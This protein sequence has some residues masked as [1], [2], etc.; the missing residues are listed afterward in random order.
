MKMVFETIIFSNTELEQMGLLG[1]AP[2]H[3]RRRLERE[4]RRALAQAGRPA[5]RTLH[6]PP[7]PPPRPLT[8]SGEAGGNLTI[9]VRSVRGKLLGYC[10]RG[11]AWVGT[12]PHAFD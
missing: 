6:L 9:L 1:P 11:D 10:H 7:A 12:S 8:W 4:R 2:G 3:G 5:R